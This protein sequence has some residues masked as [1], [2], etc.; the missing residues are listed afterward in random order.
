MACCTSVA[1]G[2]TSDAASVAV[3]SS[4]GSGGGNATSGNAGTSGSVASGTGGL[5]AGVCICG[6]ASVEDATVPLST[7]LGCVSDAV[8]APA[9]TADEPEGPV[10]TVGLAVPAAYTTLRSQR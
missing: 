9:V 6:V 1:V 5:A 7:A 10:A 4:P 8:D 3:S 2:A